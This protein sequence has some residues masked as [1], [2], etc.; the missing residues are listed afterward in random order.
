VPLAI[1]LLMS[2]LPPWSETKPS[3]TSGGWPAPKPQDKPKPEMHIIPGDSEIRKKY[4][5]SS[6]EELADELITIILMMKRF[7]RIQDE[8]LENAEI[9]LERLS[10]QLKP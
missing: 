4:E 9:D 5:S 3:L 1:L 10:K 6:F 2:Q 8:R 7:Y